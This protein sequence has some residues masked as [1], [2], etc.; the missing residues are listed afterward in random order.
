MAF[1][2]MATTSPTAKMVR[3]ILKAKMGV[4]CIRVSPFFVLGVGGWGFPPAINEEAFDVHPPAWAENK[5]R[6]AG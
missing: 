5:T 3:T 6:A 2:L 1:V 4:S